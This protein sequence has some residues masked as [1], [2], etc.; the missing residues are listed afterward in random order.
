M[1]SRPSQ[2]L[3]RLFYALK[4]SLLIA[5]QTDHF[6]ETIAGDARRIAVEHQHVTLAISCDYD[7]YPYAVIK[8]LLR[9]GTGIK[10][11]PFDLRLDR[12]SIGNRSAAL[13]PSHSVPL[14]NAL[15]RQIATAMKGAGVLSRPGWSFS[16]HQTLFYR[17]GPPEQRRVEGFSW[18]VDQ[19]MLVCSHV[20]R[21]H[22]ET[23]ATWRL[24]GSGQYK[25]F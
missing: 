6:A 3:F 13:R 24:N 10:A 5:R 2:S 19:F 20:G 18:H 17:D 9:A 25:L 12:L 14:L 23:L 21:T 4:P 16:P 1:E 22:H 7:D 8:A 11:E 15:Q